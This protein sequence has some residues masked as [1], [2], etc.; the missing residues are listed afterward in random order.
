MV[1][2]IKEIPESRR[3][4]LLKKFGYAA[5]WLKR[6][7]NYKLWQDGFH[8]VE[9]NTNI[10]LDQRLDYLPAG[11]AV[12]HNNP[13]EEGITWTADGY[14]YNSASNYAGTEYLMDIDLI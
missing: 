12:I 3:E 10:M 4:W 9:L 13:V 11:Q 14:K 5:G 1:R 2:A 8:P 6:G 7:V